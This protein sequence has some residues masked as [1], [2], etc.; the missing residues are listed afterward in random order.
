[1]M[2]PTLAQLIDMNAGAAAT[3]SRLK[4]L[5]FNEQWE[6]AKQTAIANIEMQMAAADQML[7]ALIQVNGTLRHMPCRKFTE[8]EDNFMDRQK[9][10][11]APNAAEDEDGFMN[12]VDQGDTPLWDLRD[13]LTW[14]PW[15]WEIKD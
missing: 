15:V 12:M 11:P 6:M 14:I 9:D 1:M 4:V 8:I 3:L 2:E 5:P 7:L 13:P 10:E